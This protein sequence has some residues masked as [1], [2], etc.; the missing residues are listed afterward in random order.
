MP[1]TPGA[2]NK[3]EREHKQ[4]ADISRLKA[5]VA[6]QKTVIENLKKKK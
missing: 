3:T 1:R 4:D 5:R 6:K 2:T